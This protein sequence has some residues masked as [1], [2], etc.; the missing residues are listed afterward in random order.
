MVAGDV[1][2]GS[3]PPF[4]VEG[5]WAGPTAVLVVAGGGGRVGTRAISFAVAAVDSAFLMSECSCS[6]R[7]SIRCNWADVFWY[8]SCT[9]SIVASQCV[10][11]GGVGDSE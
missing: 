11:M 5:D 6:N 8:A 2:F 7:S 4:I 10:S 1:P 3:L 9:A